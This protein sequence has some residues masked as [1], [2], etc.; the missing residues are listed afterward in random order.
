MKY[1]QACLLKKQVDSLIKKLTRNLMGE[2][3][4]DAARMRLA[5]V[6]VSAFELTDIGIG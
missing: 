2:N 3:L 1:L 4:T 6:H 5:V